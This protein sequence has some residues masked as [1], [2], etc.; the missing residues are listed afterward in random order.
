MAYSS[1]TRHHLLQ[2]SYI[3]TITIIGQSAVLAY[4]VFILQVSLYLWLTSALLL[5][6]ALLNGVTLLRLQSTTPIPLQ[7]VFCQLLADIL[8]YSA[9]LYQVGG[10][11]NPFASLLLI[12]LI[13]SATTLPKRYTWAITGLITAS[14]S[15]LLFFYIP[16]KMPDTGHQHHVTL[17]D[18]HL[19]GMWINF[20]LTAALIT[21]FVV[22]ISEHLKH[23]EQTLNQAREQRLRD[24]QLLSLATMAAGTAHEMNT[25]LS[26]MRVLLHEMTLDHPDN[27]QLLDDIDLLQSQ[28]EH[29][30]VRLQHLAHSVKEEQTHGRRLPADQF[31]HELLDRWSLLRPSARYEAPVLPAQP[32]PLLTC[33]IPLQQAFINLLN[34]AADASAA[35]LTIQLRYLATQ[36]VVEIRD[37]GAGI[38]LEKAEDI[39]KPFITTKGKGL[40]IGLFLTAST[41]TSYGGEVRL[42]NHPEGGTL[43]EVTLPTESLPIESLP[44]ESL[45]I[46]SLPTESLATES[47]PTETGSRETI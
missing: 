36:L 17:F 33:S 4:T 9:L 40:G 13:I 21:Y 2:L 46:E 3:R 44:T 29:C 15:L 14:Y 27:P 16:I 32:G 34:N 39:G 22:N 45:P 30:S 6:M 37:Q 11:G 7:E 47:L 38:P 20:L 8:L 24:Q 43:T 10:T 18:L 42:Y 31:I 5:A 1:N 41:L 19:T 28:V 25:P 26:T 35:P 23:N 12:P